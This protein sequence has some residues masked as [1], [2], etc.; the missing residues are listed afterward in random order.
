MG[1]NKVDGFESQGGFILELTYTSELNNIIAFI[2]KSK[3]CR[4]YISWECHAA[5]IKNPNS[6]SG[7]N[8]YWSNRFS[9]PMYYWGGADPEGT[10]C[11][12]GDTGTCVQV[13]NVYS[14]GYI[15]KIF[16]LF[17]FSSRAVFPYAGLLRF[18][19]IYTFQLLECTFIIAY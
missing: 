11:A 7:A 3:G 18:P 4:Q 14:F 9:E 13:Y 19:K 12:C 10:N 1:R 5:A 8:T 17:I 6:A 16:C 15:Y 2:D